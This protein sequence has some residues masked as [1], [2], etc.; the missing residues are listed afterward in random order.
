MAHTGESRGIGEALSKAPPAILMFWLVKI[1]ATTVGETGGDAVSMTLKLGYV[2]ATLIFL[3]FFAVTLVAQ[4][5]RAPLS[6]ADLL[7]GGGG[8]HHGRAPPPPTSSIAPCTSATWCRRPC[9]WPWSS[10]S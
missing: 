3:A 10:R 7:A 1:C 4:V 8:D 2:V 5:A 9:C 6:P